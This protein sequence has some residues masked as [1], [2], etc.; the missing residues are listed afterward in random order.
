MKKNMNENFEITVDEMTEIFGDTPVEMSFR[1]VKEGMDSFFGLMGLT[2]ELVNLIRK[3]DELKKHHRAY[4]HVREEI[5]EC[6]NEATEVIGGILDSIQEKEHIYRVSGTPSAFDMDE[7]G[8]YEDD[9]VTIPK[10]KYD[11]MIEDLLT[12]AELIDMVSD[13]RTRMSAPFRSLASSSR[14]MPPMSAI[15]FPCTAKRRRRPSPS[16]TAGRMSWTMTRT[17]SRTSISPTDCASSLAE[18]RESP[19]SLITFTPAIV[20]KSSKR[21]P[22]KASIAASPPR[23]ITRCVITVWTGRSAER[24]RQRNTSRA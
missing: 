7:E 4:L 15:V 13:M 17:T 24:Q 12:M 10:E 9:F 6:A 1:E 11:S 2:V 16:S 3:E 18:R 23:R 14:P 22:M 19:Y 5:A 21:C 8:E 20:S